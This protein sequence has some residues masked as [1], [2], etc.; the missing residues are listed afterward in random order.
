MVS[1]SA[2]GV[3]AICCVNQIMIEV[4]HLCV[5]I[6][7]CKKGCRH[8]KVRPPAEKKFKI[9]DYDMEKQAL[10]HLDQCVDSGLDSPKPSRGGGVFFVVLSEVCHEPSIA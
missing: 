8:N 4:A 6:W 1:D 10:H 5:S 9:C 3:D 7:T 2:V